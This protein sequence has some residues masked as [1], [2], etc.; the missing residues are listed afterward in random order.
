MNDARLIKKISYFLYPEG[1][2]DRETDEDLMK[3][4]KK[5]IAIVRRHDKRYRMD[6]VAAR[7]ADSKERRRRSR[8]LTTKD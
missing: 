6:G 4:A 7:T 2:E 8:P 5:I 3:L 1:L